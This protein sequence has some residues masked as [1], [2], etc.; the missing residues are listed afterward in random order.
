M[1]QFDLILP[2]QFILRLF[3]QKPTNIVDSP[4]EGLSLQILPYEDL[5]KQFQ[6]TWTMETKLYFCNSIGFVYQHWMHFVWKYCTSQGLEDPSILIEIYR[7]LEVFDV[8]SH[9]FLH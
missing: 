4:T 3:S 7:F 2:S 1:L 8:S 9:A 6:I 5:L